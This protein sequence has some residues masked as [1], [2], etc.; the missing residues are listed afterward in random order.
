MQHKSVALLIKSTDDDSGTLTGLASVLEKLDH[1]G[2]LGLSRRQHPL[3]RRG[4]NGWSAAWCCVFGPPGPV[5][6]PLKLGTPRIGVP[7]CGHG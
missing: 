4:Q 7:A 6:V 3:A 2:G 1:D 5:P